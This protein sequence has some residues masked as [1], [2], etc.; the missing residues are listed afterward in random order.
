MANEKNK[1]KERVPG[2]P[3]QSR[4]TPPSKSPGGMG[5]VVTRSPL[6]SKAH[7]D[8]THS[9][10]VRDRELEK[11]GGNPDVRPRGKS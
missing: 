7:N 10:R 9:T 5:Q 11:S 2:K 4:E 3:M 8:V 6:A 1:F